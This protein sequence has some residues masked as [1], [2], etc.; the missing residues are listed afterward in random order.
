MY[1]RSLK[2]LIRRL[3]RGAA[4]EQELDA[5]IQTYLDHAVDAKVA[6]GMNSEEARRAALLEFG[7]TEQVKEIIRAE[8][9][10]ARLE[11]VLA[12][13]RYAIRKLRRQPVFTV[14]AVLTI[15]LGIGTATAAF[16]LVDTILLRP[17][18]Y[19]E[20]DR[21]VTIM[22]AVPELQHDPALAAAWDRL[23]TEYNDYA[24]WSKHQAVF[25][26]TS[27]AASGKA[28]LRNRG[29]PRYVQSGIVPADFFRLLGSRASLG[30]LFAEE[31]D[32]VVVLS[33]AF[34]LREFGGDTN[35][36]G[37]QIDLS[38]FRVLVERAKT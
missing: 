23:P 11:S 9:G 19:K 21:L 17:L 28:T 2:S 8:R 27:I 34:W 35:V 20:P 25:E 18:P 7:G 31:D 22:T 32:N 24:E 3:Y 15:S 37:Q 1:W 6:A 14:L 30:R 36:I 13:I 5:E 12:D 33:H 38:F 29:E 4:V 26:E 16:T 10:G